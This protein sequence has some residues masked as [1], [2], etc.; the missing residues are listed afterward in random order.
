[1][2]DG[3]RLYKKFG[4][5]TDNRGTRQTGAFM[6]KTRFRLNLEVL[7]GR[8]TPSTVVTSVTQVAGIPVTHVATTAV[9]PSTTTS[10]TTV[11]HALAGS[12]SGS[13]I[14]TLQYM[15]MPSGY[16]FTGDGNV[17]GMGAVQM[18]I[19]VYGN[20]FVNKG[21]AHGTITLTNAKGSV[22]VQ[23]TGPM[24]PK[25]SHLPQWFQYKIVQATG[26]YKGMQDHGTLRLIRNPDAVPVRFG[27][28]FF[29]TGNFRVI[30]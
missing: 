1:M 19:D 10:T 17:K 7:E 3:A 29:E 18:Q 2:P 26:A 9:T 30:L 24:Q 14:C 5:H 27:L 6:S 20:G 11:Q 15:T 12:G 21:S 8:E 4:R 23:I 22:T 16:H 25:L 13:Y 28:R